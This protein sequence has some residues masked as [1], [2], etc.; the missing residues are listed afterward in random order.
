[1]NLK[2]YRKKSGF[3][4][5]EIALA[6]LIVAILTLVLTPVIHRQ[7][8]KSEE[9]SYYLAYRTVEKLGGQ[10]VA[11]GDPAE[12]VMVHKSPSFK[13][14]LIAQFNTRKVK[15]NRFIAK[16]T[17]QLANSE[18][19]VF[20]KLF[21]KATAAYTEFDAAT[22]YN[23]DYDEEIWLRY[24]VCNHPGQIVKQTTEHNETVE[25]EDGTSSTNTSYSSSYYQKEDLV[26]DGSGSGCMGILA[27]DTPTAGAGEESLLHGELKSLLFSNMYC[28]DDSGTSTSAIA[29]MIPD[30]TKWIRKKDMAPN[31]KILAEEKRKETVDGEQVD[32]EYVK[33][34]GPDARA[35]CNAYAGKCSSSVTINDMTYNVSVRYVS[36]SSSISDAC[37]PGDPDCE[38]DEGADG[39]MYESD[40]PGQCVLTVSYTTS[41]AG[42]GVSVSVGSPSFSADWCSRNG[43]VNMT[44]V[45]ASSGG[46]DCQCI[47]NHY[48]TGNNEKV[49][50]TACPVGQTLY[51]SGT[52][53]LCCDGDFNTKTETCC[54]VNSVYNGGDRCECITGWLLDA[55]TGLCTIPG[56]CP[57]GT[58]KAS[59]GTCVANPPI[60]RADRFCELVGE[61]WNTSSISCASLAGG[62][63]ND[64]YNAATG[65]NGRYLSI[66]APIGGF[67]NIQPNI[68]LANGLKMWIL[69]DKTASIPGLSFYS[70]PS[71]AD[72]NICKKVTLAS[73]T[74]EACLATDHGYFCGA[75][76]NCFTLTPSSF[77]AAG[78]R[79]HDARGCCVSSDVSDYHKA[80]L[81]A[82][83]PQ[84]YKK[85]PTVY[86]INGF[87]V[88]VDINGDKGSSTLWDDVYPFFISANGK[89]YPGYPLDAS[90]ETTGPN[91]LYL[92]GNS[93]KQLPVDV[94]YYEDSDG[95]EA[96]KKKIAFSNVS[97]ARGMCS[98]RRI[99]KYT[100]YCMNLGKKYNPGS[101]MGVDY[102]EKE[103]DDP[104]NK[105]P[106]D[107][108]ACYVSVRNK[109]RFF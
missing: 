12:E 61:N 38:D 89:V 75:D 86:A 109:L 29:A 72:H 35:I 33:I 17:K 57:K 95:G 42:G 36:S 55:S 8:E 11:L 46:I 53:K 25:N 78:T 108:H 52:S 10:I 73:Q 70:D 76:N 58:Q 9:Y 82:G 13:N 56:D 18:K 41:D 102:I 77:T 32:V 47:A 98:A 21:P 90:K 45:A 99:S 64:V 93:E 31:T 106:C 22:W 34:Y 80:A 79:L 74:K 2:N 14:Y 16:T 59:D 15:F 40:P 44:N 105:N 4:L 65:S 104:G 71:V 62:T 88:F 94:Y 7:L 43:Y 28:T 83:D 84:L 49:C 3:S 67:K 81:D 60:I 92:G 24:A 20:K 30:Q 68:V 23:F 50:H 1:M 27:S 91:S 87:T 69:G 85:E 103:P 66:S 48:L 6:V 63:R 39:N 97:F 37:D 96:R 26:T 54:G 107:K 100:P 19:Y 5:M 51:A 101:G